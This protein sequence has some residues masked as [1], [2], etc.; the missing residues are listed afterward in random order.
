M[1]PEK[2]SEEPDPPAEETD[3]LTL[4]IQAIACSAFA[5]FAWEPVYNIV[6][7]IIAGTLKP[8]LQAVGL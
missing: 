3:L 7:P 8:V 5:Y 1:H 4:A 2:M 6:K